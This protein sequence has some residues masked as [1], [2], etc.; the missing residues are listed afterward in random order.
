MRFIP[1]IL[2]PSRIW[3]DYGVVDTVKNVLVC[4]CSDQRNA[5]QIAGCL[6]LQHQKRLDADLALLSLSNTI[7]NSNETNNT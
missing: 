4:K 3:T 6:N 7:D 5:D 1:I 2:D